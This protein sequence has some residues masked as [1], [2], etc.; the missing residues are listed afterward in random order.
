MSRKNNAI[1]SGK[2]LSGFYFCRQKCQLFLVVF[3]GNFLRKP[4]SLHDAENVSR[5]CGQN[6]VG[7]CFMEVFCISAQK[8]CSKSMKCACLGLPS[9]RNFQLQCF[10]FYSSENGS[11]FKLARF[12]K[13]KPANRVFSHRMLYLQF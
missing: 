1:I 11:P 9:Y 5:I 4:N 8:D 6:K 7:I 13:N 12:L 3:L 2:I 10:K